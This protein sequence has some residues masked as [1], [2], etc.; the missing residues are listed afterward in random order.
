MRRL[1]C[2]LAPGCFQYNFH[3][4]RMM[5]DQDSCGG[6]SR[7]AAGHDGVSERQR[8]AE[9]TQDILGVRGRRLGK[10]GI[11]RVLNALALGGDAR[12]G[13]GKERVC[14]GL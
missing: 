11:D 6:C 12:V 4:V 9:K 14:V 1:L 13:D 2:N 7:I 5:G 3:L 8:E 10:R